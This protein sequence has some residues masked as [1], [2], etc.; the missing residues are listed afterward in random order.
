[1]SS[2]LF[3]FIDTTVTKC[4]KIGEEIERIC[5]LGQFEKKIS[6]SR[7]F[8][9]CETKKYYFRVFCQFFSGF[10]YMYLINGCNGT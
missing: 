6:I 4:Q 3:S 1:M 5:L 7:L 9:M 2:L 8:K 10:F